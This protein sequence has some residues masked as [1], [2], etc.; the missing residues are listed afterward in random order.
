MSSPTLQT[1]QDPILLRWLSRWWIS[2]PFDIPAG[3]DVQYYAKALDGTLFNSS[4]VIDTHYRILKDCLVQDNYDLVDDTYKRL[5]NVRL[6]SNPPGDSFRRP[7]TYK[8]LPAERWRVCTCAQAEPKIPPELLLATASVGVEALEYLKEEHDVR[9]PNKST[10]I[11]SSVA[12]GGI[13]IRGARSWWW[14][15]LRTRWAFLTTDLSATSTRAC[16][17]TIS[18]PRRS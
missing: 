11:L 7:H 8:Y 3:G 17:E 16:A 1:L 2:K 15:C 4:T 14:R 13:L 5:A 18:P 6:P 12:R 10:H 9:N